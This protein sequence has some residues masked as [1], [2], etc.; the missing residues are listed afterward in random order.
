MLGI[1]VYMA[2]Y[3]EITQTEDSIDYKRVLKI[4]VLCFLLILF[5]TCIIG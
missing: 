2:F 4:Q 1:G 3:L 5:S